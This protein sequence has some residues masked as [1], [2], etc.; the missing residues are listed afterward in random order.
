MPLTF[1]FKSLVI[2]SAVDAE[3]CAA[4]SII[5]MFQNHI[6]LSF[7]D[8]QNYKIKNVSDHSVS[9]LEESFLDTKPAVSSVVVVVVSSS[10]SIHL[11]SNI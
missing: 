2:V 5:N 7:N 4:V 8:I 11:L 1:I 9:F 3:Q 6:E 10:S